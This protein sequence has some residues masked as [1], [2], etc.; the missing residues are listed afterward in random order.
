MKKF[1]LSCMAIAAGVAM[2]IAQDD[3]VY[4][5]KLDFT[6]NGEK[7][8]KGVSVSQTMG[9]ESLKIEITGKSEANEITMEFETPD[10]WDYALVGAVM[11]DE[12]LPFKTRS[13]HWLSVSLA[14]KEGYKKGSSF[15]FPVNG[16]KNLGTIYLAKGDNVWE[17]PIDIEFNVK[18]GAVS[19]DP[20]ADNPS[21]PE[22]FN[23]KTFNDGLEVK[24]GYVYGVYEITVEGEVAESSFPIVIDVPEGWDGF[25]CYNWS[26]E[27][28][29]TITENNIS[30]R[31]TRSEEIEWVS[32][33]S[34]LA[35]GY[36]KGNRF[37]FEPTFVAENN[38]S[39]TVE[40]RLYKG[41]M[42]MEEYFNLDV[43]VSKGEVEKP[44]L[45]TFPD[46]F[47][48]T[49]DSDNVKVWQGNYEDISES[50]IELTEDEID[51]LSMFMPEKAIVVTGT[52]ENESLTVD[53]DL[54]SGWEGVL[55]VKV[56][57][58]DENEDVN[59]MTT[60][61]NAFEPYPM[62]EFLGMVREMSS[63]LDLSIAPGKQL[64]FPADGKMQ[65]YGCYLYIHDDGTLSGD[66]EYAGDYLDFAN[67]FVLVVNVESKKGNTV[68]SVNAID[69]NDIYYNMNGNKITKPVKGINV[70][71]VDGKATKVI[72]K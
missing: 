3:P 9:K 50:G 72:V 8:L 60:R 13:S 48:L 15:N 61:A 37:T 16:L 64:V 29:V 47:A 10:G 62:E 58:S 35:K 5:S 65:V 59:L 63:M 57:T 21:F 70:K 54:S 20:V 6:L 67:S 46:T 32:V 40:I 1:L 45:P 51:T 44:E 7:E 23:V 31:A 49:T 27:G 4:P 28:D 34:L 22:S 18:H 17:Y 38:N 68:G 24:Q 53:F 42:A 39:Q 12:D 33:E 30:P 66:P 11:G 43:R 56:V 26:H 55:P 41:E 2:G 19:D 14:T 69:C 71:V 36:V 52:T 25:I